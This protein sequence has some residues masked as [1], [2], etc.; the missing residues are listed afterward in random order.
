MQKSGKQVCNFC[1]GTSGG[2]VLIDGNG[3][4]ICEVCVE[5]C[6]DLLLKEK[7]SRSKRPRH[8][9]RFKEWTPKKIHAEL[10]RYVIGQ[11][12]AKK[13]LAIAAYNHYKRIGRHSQNTKAVLG[14]K[15]L[16]DIPLRKSNVMLVGPTGTGK[17]YLVETLSRILEV[18]FASIDATTLTEAGYAGADVEDVLVRLYYAA[19]EDINLTKRGIV[20]IDE[21]D[22]L[23]SR[24]DSI[25]KNHSSTRE[26]VQQALLKMVEGATVTVPLNKKVGSETVEIDTHN[27]LF[28]CGGAFE[29]IWDLEP[30]TKKASSTIGFLADTTRSQKVTPLDRN[31]RVTHQMLVSYGLIPEF[32]GRFPVIVSLNELT[33]NDLIRI[34]VEPEFALVKEY[35]ALLAMDGVELTFTDDALEAIAEATLAQGTGA[36]GLRG[37]LEESMRDIMFEAPSMKGKKR[38][39]ITRDDIQT[40]F[41][42]YPQ[43]EKTRMLALV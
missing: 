25:W 12:E 40:P 4:Y 26:G 21:I 19:G 37:I 5:T 23:S 13:T 16:M 34:L 15:H 38:I 42:S 43:P 31:R 10:D 7:H 11:D 36:R 32:I 2:K 18:P 22:K 6:F 33:K 35:Q 3:V 30:S 27:I 8:E 1:K 20:Y 41:D 29:G 14:Q 39:V 24:G 28:I 17:T 9:V